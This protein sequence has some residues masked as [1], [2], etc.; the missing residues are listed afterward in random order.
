MKLQADVPMDDGVRRIQRFWNDFAEVYTAEA[1]KTLTIQGSRVLHAHMDLD[2]ATRVLEVGAGAGLGT[3][4]ILSRLSPHAAL[5]ATDLAPE[6]LQRL[7][8]RLAPYQATRKIDVALANA[9]E[10]RG[11]ENGAF[12]R[13]IA[14]LVLQLTPDPNAMLQEAARVLAEDGIAGF[15]IWGAPEHSGVDTLPS[16][17]EKA[18]DIGGRGAL[19]PNF[20]LG[21]R[22]DELK[23]TI[24]SIGFR[25]V[26]S[27]PVLL[28]EEKWDGARNASAYDALEPV[29]LADFDGD[30]AAADAFRVRRHVCLTQHSNE[31]LATREMPIGLEVYIIL[32]RK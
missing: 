29:T 24:K 16:D 4:D 14:S 28:V 6:M 18:L 23:A 11:L 9:Q 26:V 22:L 17:M 1:N 31:W 27:W 8:R 2:T 7:E 30:A 20:N 12:D 3:E 25:H 15:V 32:A 10:L 13:Y 21:L 19:H 5:L